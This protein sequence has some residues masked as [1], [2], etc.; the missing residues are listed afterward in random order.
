[1]DQYVKYY[2]EINIYAEYVK[3][4]KWWEREDF[5]LIGLNLDEMD[6]FQ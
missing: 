3:F 6:Q 4:K 2:Y 5:Y 1:M